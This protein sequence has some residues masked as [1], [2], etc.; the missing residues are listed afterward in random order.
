MINKSLSE[1]IDY[2]IENGM[3]EKVWADVKADKNPGEVLA[4][5]EGKQ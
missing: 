5:L 4:Y 1:L 3:I 2:A